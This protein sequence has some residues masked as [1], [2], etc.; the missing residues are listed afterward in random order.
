[1]VDWVSK[2]LCCRC[3]WPYS[4]TDVLSNCLESIRNLW[5]QISIKQRIVVSPYFIACLLC[6]CNLDKQVFVF[7][8]C[9]LM[10]HRQCYLLI[11]TDPYNLSMITIVLERKMT[12]VIIDD[13][14]HSH[15]DHILEPLLR[16]VRFT[17]RY[18][19]DQST[20]YSRSQSLQINKVISDSHIWILQQPEVF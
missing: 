7:N 15:L 5:Q 16:I 2:R 4:I 11:H 1:M 19:P 13:Y 10:Y 9:R 3:S 14:T 18:R 6:V 17:E 12:G 20:L 8:I